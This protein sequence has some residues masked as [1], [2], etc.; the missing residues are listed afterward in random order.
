MR[1]WT[2]VHQ[3]GGGFN[4]SLLVDDDEC[5]GLHLLRQTVLVN[6]SDDLKLQDESCVE[7]CIVG[8]QHFDHEGRFS[9]CVYDKR[10]RLIQRLV[11]TTNRK[12]RDRIGNVRR[13]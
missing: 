8:H 3:A 6:R 13:G 4:H 12:E 2:F 5:L 10:K 7:R 11:A 1:C 9:T